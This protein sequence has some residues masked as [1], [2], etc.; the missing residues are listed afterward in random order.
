MRVSQN[1]PLVAVE[2]RLRLGEVIEARQR[3]TIRPSWFALFMKAYALAAARRDELRRSFLTFPWS[4]LHQHSCNVAHLVIAR[5]VADEEG[6]LGVMIRYPEQ[7]SL[8]EIDAVIRKARTEPIEQIAA[9]RRVLL[10]SRLPGPLRRLAFWAGVNVSGDWRAR[11]FG[12]FLLTGVG[13]LGSASL[14]VLSPLSTT[15][16]YGVFEADGSVLV[17]L[18]YDHRIMDGVVPAEALQELEQNLN[19]PILEE[20]RGGQ[21]RVA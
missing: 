3:L 6:V 8:A 18:F 1:V 19:G 17:R 13:A 4:R 11:F 16:T 21:R 5:R 2:R 9:F 10:M 14:H 20:L 15:L 7:L 12:T